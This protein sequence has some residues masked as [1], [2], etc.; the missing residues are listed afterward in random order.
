MV[1]GAIGVGHG[2]VRRVLS[3]VLIT[4]AC[5]LVAPGALSAWARY[6]IGDTDAYVAAMA[7][8]ASDAD[9]HTAVADAVA[10]A[11]VREIDTSELGSDEAVESFVHEAVRSFAGTSAF[12]TAWDAAN[13]AAHG[14]V[15]Q[16]LYGGGSRSTGDDTLAAGRTGHDAGDG[17]GGDGVG[18]GGDG[19]G[20][21]IDLAPI[22]EQVKRQLVADDVPYADRIPVRH[23]EVTVMDSA[24]S[25]A[26]PQLR[27]GFRM[28][29]ITGFWLPVA[30]L[31]L[32]VAGIA[33]AVRRRRAVT[34]AAFGMALGAALLE[35]AIVVG[36][37][38]T[39]D[40]LPP[41]VSRAAAGAV[42][43]ALTESLRTV[44]WIILAVGVAV[45]LVGWVLGRFGGV[46]PVRRL[47]EI[48][49]LRSPLISRDAR[50]RPGSEEPPQ[51]P[52]AEQTQVRA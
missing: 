6:E 41:D 2:G 49:T 29:Q 15:M 21:T 51:D 4:V 42:Y 24:S 45:M 26:L 9:V 25:G 19:G 3:A 38:L 35:A 31:V 18:D 23:T 52:A 13:R 17:E 50:P 14:A 10:D 44:A 48:R 34:A 12:R 32:A 8:L 7:P 22:T 27:K 5:A 43:D 20:V 37:R 46:G 40:D 33:L 28:L 16:A 47:R 36:R 30:V 39:L 1:A 11:V